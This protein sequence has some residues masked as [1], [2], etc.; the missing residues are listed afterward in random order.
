MSM[1]G[2]VR[3]VGGSLASHARIRHLGIINP[4]IPLVK[5]EE[6]LGLA[7]GVGLLGAGLVTKG[8]TST[9]MLILGGLVTAVTGGLTLMRH[10]QA[11]GPAVV[12]L[13][14]PAPVPPPKPASTSQ[15]IQQYVTQLSPTV[16]PLL[17]DLFSSLKPAESSPAPSGMV[18]SLT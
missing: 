12:S 18:T 7:G 6:A 17:K 15:Q 9:I 11:P 10:V 14:G 13:P 8:K 2:S 3:F 1:N 16:A 4:N 5:T